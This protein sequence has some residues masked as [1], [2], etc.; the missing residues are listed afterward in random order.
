VMTHSWALCKGVG[1]YGLFGGAR[2]R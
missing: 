2:C 1:D